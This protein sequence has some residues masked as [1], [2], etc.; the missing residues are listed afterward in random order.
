LNNL[1]EIKAEVEEIDEYREIGTSS[2]MDT[3]VT[4]KPLHT[5]NFL[6]SAHQVMNLLPLLDCKHE[7]LSDRALDL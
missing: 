3:Y 6:T 4:Q 2:L 1:D 5:T 7:E